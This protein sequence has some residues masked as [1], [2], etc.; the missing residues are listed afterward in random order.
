MRSI[1]LA[2]FVRPFVLIFMFFIAALIAHWAL[3]AVP[4]GRIKQILRKPMYMGPGSPPETF[5]WWQPVFWFA[6]FG[7]M[8]LC[9]PTH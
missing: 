8:M 7:V 2:V 9:I 3:K 5:S 6:L 4:E 1:V